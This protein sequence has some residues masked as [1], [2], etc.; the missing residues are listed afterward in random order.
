ML[1][2]TAYFHIKCCIKFLFKIKIIISVSELNIQY[3]IVDYITIILLKKIIFTS[4]SDSNKSTSS[5]S[6]S[7]L[8][9]SFSGWERTGNAFL[10]SNVVTRT[11]NCFS[12]FCNFSMS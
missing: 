12:R 10:V 1:I 6:S 11:S 5:S 2:N 3:K 9:D 4:D 8:E 7:F